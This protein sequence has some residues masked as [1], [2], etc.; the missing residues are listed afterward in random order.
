MGDDCGRVGGHTDDHY[1]E[2]TATLVNYL[3]PLHE[4]ISGSRERRSLKINI[5]DW[6]SYRDR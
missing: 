2:M 5:P 6:A 3:M 4:F 1:G